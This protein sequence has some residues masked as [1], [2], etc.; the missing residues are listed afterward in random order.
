MV[1]TAWEDDFRRLAGVIVIPDIGEQGQYSIRE[2]IAYDIENY[3]PADYNQL[4]SFASWS[5]NVSV[6]DY[7]LSA[8]K[9]ISGF[10]TR[11]KFGSI[12]YNSLSTFINADFLRHEFQAFAP[13]RCIVQP[14]TYTDLPYTI[15]DIV[16]QGEVLSLSQCTQYLVGGENLVYGY[17]SFTGATGFYYDLAD[18]VIVNFSVPYVVKNVDLNPASQIGNI[19]VQ[20]Y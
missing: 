19:L 11:A 20:N 10:P 13:Q 17:S 9:Y 16:V 12:T 15:A 1:V 2:A 6:R 5:V 3:L 8:V 4:V 18:T 7:N 14:F